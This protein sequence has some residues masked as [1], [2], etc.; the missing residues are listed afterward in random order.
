MFDN[1]NNTKLMT[2]VFAHYYNLI[3]YSDALKL[4][5]NLFDN[6]I[7]TKMNYEN[8]DSNE[9]PENNIV[10]CTHPPV[11]TLGKSGNMD[12]LLLNEDEMEAKGISIH[13]I[14]RGGDITYHGPGQLVVYPILDLEQLNV[15]LSQFIF[16]IEQ[17]IIKALKL[18]GI[19]SNQLENHTGVWINGDKNGKKDRKICAIGFKLSRYVSMHGFALNVSTDLDYFNHIVPCG[20]TDKE[21]TSISKEI[22][23]EVDMGKVIDCLKVAF[24]DEFEIQIATK[25]H[26]DFTVEEKKL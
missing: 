4:Q 10:F 16:K 17:V 2:D 24:M 15:T 18:I 3:P 23:N 25:Y 26:M 6:A 22:G 5:Q 20:I 14:G 9:K 11:Y 13:K 7:Q 19:N 8:G 21:V 12:N 1:Q